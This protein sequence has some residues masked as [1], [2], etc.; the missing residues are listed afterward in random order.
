M[1]PTSKGIVYFLSLLL[2]TP[3]IAIVAA[4]KPG[5]NIG[6]P[7]ISPAS[8]GPND[9]VT[10]TV[11]VTAGAGVQ[12]VTLVYTI[13]SWRTNST[14][15]APYDDT[16][17]QASAKIP[18]QFNGGH[19]EY[20]IVAFDNSNN[21]AVKDNNGTYFTYTVPAPTSL[22]NTNMWIQ[23]AVVL[24]AVGAAAAVAFYGLRRKRTTN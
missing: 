8:P 22:I 24:T 2:L 3:T 7:T 15:P 14:L 12:N 13:D 18:A 11:T 6:T 4:P 9:Q 5:P 19:V 10:V 17:N 23:L 21:R 16:S 20:Y 1:S